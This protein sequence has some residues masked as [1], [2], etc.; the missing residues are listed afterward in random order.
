MS[1]ALVPIFPLAGLVFTPGTILP[2]HVFEPRYREM[3]AYSEAHGGRIAMATVAPGHEAEMA[4]N[5][6]IWPEVGVGVIEQL[7]RT[8]DG[9]SVFRLRFEGAARIEGE[10]A[11]PGGFRLARV[12]PLPSPSDDPGE[13]SGVRALALQ[14]AARAGGVGVDF[15]ALP[16]TVLL[17]AS[18]ACFVQDP[19]LRRRYLAATRWADRRALV[20][21]ALVFALAAQ[22]P[23]AEA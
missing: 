18:I 13:T 10:V 8:V 14:L 15:A 7:Q 22:R 20:E 11:S 3:V 19:G 23:A 5:P 17:D 2:L 4:G 9:R 1:S 6:P 21:D 16:P 12:Q